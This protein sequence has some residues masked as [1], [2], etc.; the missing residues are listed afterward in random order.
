[1]RDFESDL[2]ES[3]EEGKEEQHKEIKRRKEMKVDENVGFRQ[4]L[5]RELGKNTVKE[6][7]LVRE[8]DKEK[9]A[10]GTTVNIDD[11][12][13]SKYVAVAYTHPKCKYYWGKITRA[14][15]QDSDAN[16]DKVE[17]D[18]LRKRTISA[19]PADWD[20]E[21]K[22]GKLKEIEI[23]ETKHIIYGPMLPTFKGRTMKFPD[24]KAMAALR[25]LEGR[26][27]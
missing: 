2:E 7:D 14:F 17:I 21:D 20:W 4:V 19:N 6:K 23:I 12:D 1:M 8:A 27:K 5:Q 15:S 24:L 26:L 18:F 9:R 3:L 11:A 25:E 16:N 10:A 22:Q 13:I